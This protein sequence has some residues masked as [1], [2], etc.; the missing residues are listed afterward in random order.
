M[1]AYM[2][3]DCQELA[4]QEELNGYKMSWVNLSHKNMEDRVH[5]DQET[6]A[7]SQ[8]N[9]DN[10]GLLSLLQDGPMSFAN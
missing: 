8:A 2:S 6:Q 7:S 5:G 9:R 10:Y 1:S 4:V 3:P